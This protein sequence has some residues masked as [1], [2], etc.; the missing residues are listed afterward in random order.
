MTWHLLT[1]HFGTHDKK[2]QYWQHCS[3]S[4]S[5]NVFVNFLDPNC[6][7]EKNMVNLSLRMNTWNR[8]K[9]TKHW[10]SI[11]YIMYDMINNLKQLACLLCKG[12]KKVGTQS[13]KKK[14]KR[15]LGISSIPVFWPT[16]PPFSGMQC[17]PQGRMMSYQ[18][19]TLYCL[20][21]YHTYNE[22]PFRRKHL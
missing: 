7:H 11:T 5:S 8:L 4:C 17:H 13:R 15:Y 21:L 12:K 20:L 6:L 19:R 9:V 3:S 14:K 18:H 2:L 1:N 10:A 16:L 22:T